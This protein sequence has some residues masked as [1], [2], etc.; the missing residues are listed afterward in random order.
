MG[1][2]DLYKAPTTAEAVGQEPE[3]SARQILDYLLE[4]GFVGCSPAAA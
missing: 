3:A 1:I 2:D 4:Q